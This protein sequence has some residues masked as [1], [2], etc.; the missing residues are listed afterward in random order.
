[1]HT[2]YIL[3]RCLKSYK[4]NSLTFATLTK[5]CYYQYPEGN[6]KEGKFEYRL[7]DN[8]YPVNVFYNL[9]LAVKESWRSAHYQQNVADFKF[10]ARTTHAKDSAEVYVLVIGETARS[11]RISA[12]HKSGTY[13]DAGTDS[14][15]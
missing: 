3:W 9:G 15:P 4:N 5:L 14:V 8:M 6:E 7:S 1:M 10:N 11:L 12:P 2:F 13:E